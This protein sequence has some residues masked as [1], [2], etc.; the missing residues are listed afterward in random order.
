MVVVKFVA[1]AKFAKEGNVLA[2]DWPTAMERVPIF[3]PTTPTA[4][5]AAT[6]V[7]PVIVA[8]EDS[9]FFNATG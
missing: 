3:L 7:D 1:M 4:E 8:K 9:V 5:F 2:T 6:R